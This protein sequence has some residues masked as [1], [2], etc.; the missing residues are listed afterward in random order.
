MPRVCRGADAA[1]RYRAAEPVT[2]N[3]NAHQLAV[4][5]LRHV[6]AELCGIEAGPLGDFY[7]Q[8]GKRALS[9]RQELG[10]ATLALI[11]MLNG[12]EFIR[13]LEWLTGIAG[14]RPDP[15]LAGG[16][17]H[18]IGRGGFLKIHTD[19]NWHR[20]LQMHRRVNLLLYLNEGWRG[21]WGGAL[22]LWREDMSACAVE[23]LPLFN[24]MVIFSTTDRS[25]HGHPEPLSCPEDITRDSI[26]LYYYSA[27]QA[28]GQRFGSSEL[29]NYRPRQGERFGAKHA[30]HQLLLRRPTLRRMLRR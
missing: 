21:E 19:F 7:G 22:E 23:I 10:S 15:G 26:A 1:A 20:G 27:D 5:G 11:D 25:Y 24:R 9:R 13:W 30:A 12:Q 3:L 8:S 16:G 4:H 29:T 17:V 2:H 18:R 14:L 6:A 28:P